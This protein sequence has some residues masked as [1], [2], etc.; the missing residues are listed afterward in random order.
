M[1]LYYAPGACSLAPH[2]VARE[3]G[4][5]LELVK[6]DLA[7][8]RT[9]AGEDFQLVNSKGSVPALLLNDGFLLTEAAVIIQYLADLNPAVE[10]IPAVGRDRY[11]A[12][13]WLN[14]IATELH[15]GF[16]PL[17]NAKT[18]PETRE[19]VKAQLATKF[20]FLDRHVAQHDY[21]HGGRFGVADAYAFTI[22][23]WAKHMAI[24]LG[25]WP[26]LSAYVERIGRRDKV[27]EAMAAEGLI[28]AAEAA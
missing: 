4:L 26:N 14:F 1:K 28:E 27:R 23:G 3:A 20:A 16:G 22:L 21:L 10:L 6:V 18:P 2:I 15:K 11:V 8:K 9:E 19:M 24:D 5:P 13:Q 17:W 7:T 25:R 12:Q